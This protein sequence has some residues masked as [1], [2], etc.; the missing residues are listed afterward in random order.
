M[1]FTTQ[2][3]STPLPD[4]P[5]YSSL[6][7][8]RL[9]N[10]FIPVFITW[11]IT[12]RCNLSC[13]C[14]A[15]HSGRAGDAGGDVLERLAAEV[16]KCG[17]WQVSLTGGEPLVH[18]ELETI[19]IT[20]R[21]AGARVA[22]NT[23]GLLLPDRVSAVKRASSVGLSLDGARDTHEITRGPGSYNGALLALETCRSSRIPIK[24]NAVLN[25]HTT[26]EDVDHLLVLAQEY[27]APIAFQP[28]QQTRL[29]SHEAN[30]DMPDAGH[31]RML[32]SHIERHK[33]KHPEFILNSRSGLKHMAHWPQPHRIPCGAGRFFCRVDPRG[34]VYACSVFGR[35]KP[36]G[37]ILENDFSSLFHGA[38]Q[39]DC[40]ECWC[41]DRVESNLIYS[42][43]IEPILNYFQTKSRRG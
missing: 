12:D 5:P 1:Q 11:V 9:L 16:R 25:R 13:A 32:V 43:H 31:F 29:G 39:P 17:T 15:R 19:I 2:G 14:C 23:N 35:P 24:I 42:F 38:E 28:S 10:K 22:V 18:P 7:K 4:S 20:L 3:V 37:N 8:T 6:L 40:A 33:K 41:G 36:A 30:P 21:V 27:G 34:N 26:K